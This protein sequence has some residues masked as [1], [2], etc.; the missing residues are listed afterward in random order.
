MK[1]NVF[2]S[3]HGIRNIHRSKL[4]LQHTH[5]GKLFLQLLLLKVC[6][7]FQFGQSR[8]TYHVP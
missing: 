5:C 7:S 1:N 6:E 8:E 4:H 2:Q 3:S